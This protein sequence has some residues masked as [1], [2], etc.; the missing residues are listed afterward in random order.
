MIFDSIILDKIIPALGWSLINSLWIGL[1]AYLIMQFFF[2]NISENRANVKYNFGLAFYSIIIISTIS[3]FLSYIN[4]PEVL[5]NADPEAT[6]RIVINNQAYIL[7]NNIEISDNGNPVN[8]Y[9]AAI[10]NLVN[11]NIS[12][13][14]Y[15]WLAGMFYYSINTIGGYKLTKRLEKD[16]RPIR[17]Y[18][19][20][21]VK[22]ISDLLQ[23]DKVVSIAES[24]LVKS[25]LVI[26]YLKPVLLLPLGM[27]SSMPVP[28]IEAIIAHEI[29]H[30]KRHDYFVN[31]IQSIFDVIFFFNPF[32]KIISR[33][34][35]EEREKCCDDIA[36]E[37]I[38]NPIDLARALSCAVEYKEMIPAAASAFASGKRGELFCRVKRILD[39]DDKSYRGR[40]NS[41][42]VM[43]LFALIFCSLLSLGFVDT[44]NQEYSSQPT[45]R[46]AVPA[47]SIAMPNDLE[48][49]SLEHNDLVSL[50]HSDI[51]EERL[52]VIGNDSGLN[53]TELWKSAEEIQILLRQMNNDRNYPDLS[54]QAIKRQKEA[55]QKLKKNSHRQLKRLDYSF[56]YEIKTEIEKALKD[57]SQMEPD[58]KFDMQ[59]NLDIDELRESLEEINIVLND[60]DISY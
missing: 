48:K 27:I 11:N 5:N 1:M 3:V 59:F 46:Q 57:I 36:M 50:L 37:Y 58:N 16:T 47:K 19:N 42:S 29:A 28:Q 15:L 24:A 53:R 38:S 45:G 10:V 23:I 35:R 40:S 4:S 13:L 55:V 18:W 41:S 17:K 14:I 30:V 52:P 31:L 39:G 6:S 7:F 20:N 8:L 21:K 22:E 49:N 54:K 43:L 34:I 56:N 12:V 26:G 44:I 2:N 25:P 33:K 51:L 32:T 60:L 9:L